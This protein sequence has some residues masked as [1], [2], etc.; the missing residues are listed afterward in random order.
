MGNTDDKNDLSL[1]FSWMVARKKIYFFFKLF[2]QPLHQ[3]FDKQSN[4]LKN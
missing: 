2:M 1:P 3:T 4:K